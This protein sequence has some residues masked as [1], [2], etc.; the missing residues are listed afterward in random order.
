MRLWLVHVRMIHTVQVRGSVG[1]PAGRKTSKDRSASYPVA[2]VKGCQPSGAHL[3]AFAPI[4]LQFSAFG[5]VKNRTL[6]VNIPLSGCHL[7]DEFIRRSHVCR[8][9]YMKE[10]RNSSTVAQLSFFLYQYRV[11]PI[12]KSRA[13][14]RLRYARIAPS[15]GPERF[16]RVTRPRNPALFRPRANKD[17]DDTAAPCASGTDRKSISFFSCLSFA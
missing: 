10:L 14:L 4:P 13:N 7:Q 3:S 5:C 1:P 16:S 6:C 11:F 17:G 2:D 15:L 9:I 8:I 12:P